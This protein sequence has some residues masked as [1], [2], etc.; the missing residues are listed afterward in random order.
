MHEDSHLQNPID[1]CL[2]NEEVFTVGSREDGTI[3]RSRFWDDTDRELEEA[4][5]AYDAIKSE[6]HPKQPL[7][8]DIIIRL[9]IARGYA[10]N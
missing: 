8:I 3:N 5:I 10:K 7:F 4:M 2:G 6:E 1:K 9:M